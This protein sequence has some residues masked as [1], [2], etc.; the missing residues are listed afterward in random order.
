MAHILN[1][2]L[3]SVCV[4][5]IFDH[6]PLSDKILNTKKVEKCALLINNFVAPI[7]LL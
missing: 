6:F 2:F 3:N 1:I 5:L 4:A 7:F